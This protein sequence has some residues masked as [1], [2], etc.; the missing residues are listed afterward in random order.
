MNRSSYY[1]RPKMEKRISTCQFDKTA[2]SHTILIFINDFSLFHQS[3]VFT[4]RCCLMRNPRK[5][6]NLLTSGHIARIHYVTPSLDSPVK[7]LK[8]EFGGVVLSMTK[9]KLLEA[10]LRIVGCF[11]YRTC[12]KDRKIKEEV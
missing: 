5:S 9:V 11:S 6:F 4:K 1:V 2:N 8:H 10:T 7:H 3:I 12:K